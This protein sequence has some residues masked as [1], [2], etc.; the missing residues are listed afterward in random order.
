MSTPG[1][2]RKSYG[3]NRLPWA[4][5]LTYHLGVG[6]AHPSGF[7][8]QAECLGSGK[9]YFDAENSLSD[10]GYRTVNLNLG[11]RGEHLAVTIWGKNLLNA[12]YITK[13]LVARGNTIVED[14]QP[15]SFGTTVSWSF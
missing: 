12:R 6:Y 3:G 13:K 4:P 1:G 11:Y 5:D 7:F 14:G 15:F 9:Q 8:A 10:S 2:G